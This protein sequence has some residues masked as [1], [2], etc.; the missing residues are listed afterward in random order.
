MQIKRTTEKFLISLSVPAIVESS[1]CSYFQDFTSFSNL[2]ILKPL[3]TERV[4]F[5]PVPRFI[6]FKIISAVEIRTIAASKILNL[7]LK[8]YLTPSPSNFMIIS[9]KKIP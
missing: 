4:E 6:E 3:N 1:S 9:A 8:Y 2:R 5:D 7:S